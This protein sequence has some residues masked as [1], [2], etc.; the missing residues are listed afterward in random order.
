MANKYGQL[1]HQMF[2]MM[3]LIRRL[4]LKTVQNQHGLHHGKGHVL[5]ELMDHDNLSQTELAELIGIRPASVTGLLEKMEKDQLVIRTPDRDDH[6]VTRVIISDVG[7]K[8]VVENQIF[9]DQVDQLVF[10]ALTEDEQVQLEG[11]FGKL[12][13]SLHDFDV[14][15]EEQFKR[16]LKQVK[17]TKEREQTD[18]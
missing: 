12:L 17:I 15:D 11:L 2:E 18:D 16:V 14:Q 4:S 1:S 6:R 8:A 3:T 5:R 13:T 7:R 10:G 9:R